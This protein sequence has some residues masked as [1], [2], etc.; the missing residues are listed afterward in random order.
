MLALWALTALAAAPL[1]DTFARVDSS[2]VTVRAGVRKTQRT[3]NHAVMEVGIVT[4]SGVLVHEKG[5]VV[6]AAH[7]VEEAEL[8]EVEFKDGTRSP[9]TIVTLSRSE[10]LALLAA[11]EV[12]KKVFVAPLADSAAL[13]PGQRVFAIGAPLGLEHTLTVGVVSALRKNP[14]GG[15]VPHELVQT[16]VAVNQGNSGGPLFTESGEVAG[17]VSFIMS[18][19][20][21]SVGLNFAV[22]SNAVRTRLFEQALPWI[23]VSLRFVPREVAEVFN[24]PLAGAFLVEK[25]QEGGAADKAGLVGGTVR[26]DVGG[27][28]VWLGGDLI[29]KVGDVDADDPAKV[30]K[31]LRG[32]KPGDRIRYEVLRKGK[33]TVVEVPVPDSPRVPALAM[34]AKR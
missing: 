20:G 25:V 26:A 30:G 33:K 18:T 17:I 11:Q 22:P 2:V 31:Y 27:N 7:V 32:L 3:E 15:L 14:P 1:E 13:R 6:T 12:P 28:D 29:T 8:V 24:W 23:G 5:F 19:S 9:A 4:G 34:P 21:G 10:D 16:D